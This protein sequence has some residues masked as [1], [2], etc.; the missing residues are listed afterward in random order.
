MGWQEA[1]SLDGSPELPA[2]DMSD[3]KSLLF[4]EFISGQVII[5]V[6]VLSMS[7]D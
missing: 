1:S 2:H 7:S 5:A 6:P 4:F 3:Q